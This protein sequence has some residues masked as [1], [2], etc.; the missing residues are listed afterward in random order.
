MWIVCKILWLTVT[1]YIA[2]ALGATKTETAVEK[3]LLA[4][5]NSL[6]SSSKLH[7]CTLMRKPWTHFFKIYIWKNVGT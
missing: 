1:K 4:K 5:A 7:K 3:C 6:Q 2:C